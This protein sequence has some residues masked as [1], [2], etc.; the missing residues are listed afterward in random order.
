MA[1][2]AQSP[3][4]SVTN[5]EVVGVGNARVSE[6]LAENNV[7][8][9][10][11]LVLIRTGSVEADLVADPW[12]KTASVERRFPDRVEIQIAERWEVAV[13]STAQGWRTISDDGHIMSSVPE[14]PPGLAQVGAG[15][16]W[17][18][19]E[20]EAVSEAMLGVVEF[21][22]ALPDEI[23]GRTIISADG[24]VLAADIDGH[25]V[26]LGTPTLMAAK[27]AA[28]AAVLDDER[29]AGDAIIDLV[30]PSRPAVSNPPPPA[31][32]GTP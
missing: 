21:L 6:V 13:V 26:R 31:V 11:P 20:E 24:G 16:A 10:R 7:Y 18:S 3:W 25:R 9:G 15:V 30:A 22:A 1:W 29:L 17:A 32:G 27:A 5:I 14:L 4:F 28:L 19:P 2:A 12:V 8:E 23:L